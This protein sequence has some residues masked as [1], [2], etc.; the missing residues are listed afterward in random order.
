MQTN[1]IFT[2]FATMAMLFVCISELSALKYSILFS[3]TGASSSVDSVVVHNLNRGTQVTVPSGYILSLT[4]GL[5]ALNDK[6]QINNV[7]IAPNPIQSSAR[8]SFPVENA[9]IATVSVFSLSGNLITALSQDVSQGQNSFQLSL[10]QGNYLL[11]ITADG[12]KHCSQVISHNTAVNAPSIAFLDNQPIVDQPILKSAKEQSVILITKMD[13][14]SGEVL[15]YKAYSGGYLCSIVS[16]IPTVSKT[17]NFNFIDCT[18]IDGN[19]YPIVTIGTQTWMAENL[20]VT[21]YRNGDFIP[22][23]A[24]NATWSTLTT[25]GM[26][27]YNNTDKADT[28]SKYGRFYNWYAVN[29]GR[30][31]APNGW[32]VASEIEW[33]T[34][35]AFVDKHFAHSLNG[36]KAIACKHNWKSSPASIYN[37]GNNPSVNNSTGFEAIPAGLRGGQNPMFWSLYDGAVFWSSTDL[38]INNAWGYS[39]SSS[40]SAIAKSGGGLQLGFSVRCIIDK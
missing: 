6:S 29:D 38:D 11:S 15:L 21:K 4:D 19:H 24:D 16:D 32:H 37:V 20:R 28:I 17:T 14:S 36:A 27:T 23:A 5:T 40:S 3:G 34:L 30:K 26:C 22:N 25:G 35:I 12:H 8:V 31:I 10:P 1:R 39:L 33:D 18:D 9:G 2:V 13:Y 7:V